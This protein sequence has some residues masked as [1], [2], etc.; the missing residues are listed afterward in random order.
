MLGR[1]NAQGLGAG[2]EAI[3]KQIVVDK[4]ESFM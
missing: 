4:G 1:Y 2:V 3:T